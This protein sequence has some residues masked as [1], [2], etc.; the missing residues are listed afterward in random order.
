[1]LW[2]PALVLAQSLVP[3]PSDPQY[4]AALA[5]KAEGYNTE[6]HQF[7][8]RPLGFGLEAFVMDPANRQLIDDFFDAGAADFQAFSGKHPYEVIT[9]Y[10]E[11]GDLGMF[12][13]V[14]AAGDAFR[15]AALR[16]EAAPKA[17]VDAAREQLK[18]AMQG[19][20]W[21][22]QITGVPGAT[23]R[24]LRRVTPEAGEPP[25]PNLPTPPLVP[26]FDDAGMPLPQPKDGAWR[27]D[28]SGQ[29]PF[30]IWA[31]NP[32]K[33]QLDGYV[34][35]LGA[36]YD[37]TKGDSTFPQDLV[38]QL[39]ADAAAI[40]QRLMRKVEISPGVTADLV[41]VDADGRPTG[42]HDLSAEEYIEGAVAADP[43]NGFNALMALGVMRT[44]F[45]I[46]GDEQ[47]GKF[48]FDELVTK[49]RYL[50]S[51]KSTISIMYMGTATNF[52][53]VNMAFLVAYDVLRY[54][55]DPTLAAHYRDILET[56]LYHPG[57]SRQAGGLGQSLFDFIYAGFHDG[58][59]DAAAQGLQ[60]L[61]EWPPAPWWYVSVVNCDDDELDAGVCLAVDGTTVIHLANGD[62]HGGGAVAQE[63]L[64]MRLRP[65]SDFE[66]RDDPFSPN[67]GGVP[68]LLCPGG[69]FHAAYWMGR[70]LKANGQNISPLARALPGTQMMTTMTPPPP[71]KTCGCGEAELGAWVLGL[72]LVVLRT[73]SKR[74]AHGQR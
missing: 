39:Q 37:A 29:L 56:E 71:T 62:A 7:M 66:W 32:S 18:K 15:Y 47:I 42:A 52:S 28:Q 10:A 6:L 33:D 22:T 13:G 36:A 14:E 21:Y 46:S 43:L 63:V 41:I 48:Y 34:F 58:G 68:E 59:A 12:G 30:L 61:K 9:A 17:Q 44:L 73:R 19:L 35:A 38:T 26:L 51:A 55:N 74:P 40:G 54:E 3:G 70:W 72:G 5:A 53:N 49:R 11:E 60:T 8:T 1:V 20:H 4:D 25:V 31:D 57:S 64:P 23:A 45:H 67:G 50:S 2:V 69:D 27:A 16:D 65:P 24:G